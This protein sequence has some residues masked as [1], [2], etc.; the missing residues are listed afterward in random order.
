M[1]GIGD[2]ERAI[3]AMG[4]GERT[5]RIA[6]RLGWTVT[7]TRYYIRSLE[8]A[9]RVERHPRYTADNDIFWRPSTPSRL[10]SPPPA[11]AKGMGV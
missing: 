1:T 3:E 9:G 4:E 11:R 6:K 8:E 10:V 7:K 5:F 2:R